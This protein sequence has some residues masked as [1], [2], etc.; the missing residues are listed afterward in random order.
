MPGKL[1]GWVWRS[2]R[3]PASRVSSIL[4]FPGTRDRLRLLQDAG[5]GTP[6]ACR[7]AGGTMRLTPWTFGAHENGRG[8]RIAMA[9]LGLDLVRAGDGRG[10]R[11]RSNLCADVMH[12]P[13]ALRT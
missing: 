1:D 7:G 11:I 2:L 8:L 4:G 5:L 13:Q 10:S 12:P 9:G 3:L 6:L